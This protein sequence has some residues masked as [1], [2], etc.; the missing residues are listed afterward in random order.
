[1]ELNLL[2][3]I[4]ID[5]KEDYFSLLSNLEYR[6]ISSSN[7][8]FNEVS[9]SIIEENKE[10][11]NNIKYL[12]FNYEEEIFSNNHK[13]NKAIECY[14]I[15]RYFFRKHFKIKQYQEDKLIFCIFR[16]LNNE[17]KMSITHN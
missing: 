12:E 2:T 1:M 5:K 6:W 17:T 4:I 13:S 16:Y 9:N 10:F 7:I 15:L 14:W 11:R 3:N 8:T